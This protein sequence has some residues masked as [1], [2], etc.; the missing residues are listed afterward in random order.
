MSTHTQVSR[1]LWFEGIGFLSIVVL[2]WINELTNLPYLLGGVQDIPDWRECALET[3]IVLLVAIPLMIFT[4]RSVSRL[5]YLEGFLRV[6]AWCKKLGHDGEWIPLEEFF[7]RKF[8]TETS[9]GICSACMDEMKA[10][11]KGRRVA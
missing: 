2:S 10:K 1:V 3:F 6:C 8:E 9:H 5:Y 7:E 4:K 11:T